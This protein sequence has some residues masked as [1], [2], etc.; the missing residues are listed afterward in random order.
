MFL[1]ASTP[2][3]GVVR[4]YRGQA[5]SATHNLSDEKVEEI[6]DTLRSQRR[7]AKQ[8]SIESNHMFRDVAVNYALDRN[9][10]RGIFTIS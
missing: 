4:S 5:G 8:Y 9:E 6:R 10:L 1:E 3:V 2:L 7:K